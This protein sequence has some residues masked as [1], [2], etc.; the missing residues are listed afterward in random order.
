MSLRLLDTKQT[1]QC[2]LLA[3][4]AWPSGLRRWF[5]APVISMAWVRI[6]PLPRF[7]FL[8]GQ[9]REAEGYISSREELK[10]SNAGYAN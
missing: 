5:Q 4:V 6:P 9:W 2:Q 10:E 1:E 7:L 8:L 3:K